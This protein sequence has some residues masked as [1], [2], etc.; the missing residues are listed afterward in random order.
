[1]VLN[2]FTIKWFRLN[3]INGAESKSKLPKHFVFYS[4]HTFLQKFSPSPS[5]SSEPCVHVNMLSQERNKCD[6][7]EEINTDGHSLSCEVK[8]KHRRTHRPS[9]EVKNKHRRTHRQSCEMKNKHIRTYRRSCEVKN[10]HI[11]TYRRSCEVK[12]RSDGH[13]RS[14]EVK[15]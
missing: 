12:I 9:C 10:K 4:K 13:T 1:M 6:T 5:L 15:K 11:R 2:L 3:I 14:C 7:C 8:N